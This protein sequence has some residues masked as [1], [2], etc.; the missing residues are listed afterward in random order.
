MTP[1]QEAFARNIVRGMNPKEAYEAAGYKARG[2]TASN[3]AQRLLKNPYVSRMIEEGKRLADNGAAWDRE[4]AVYRLV[5]VNTAS[6]SAIMRGSIGTNEV[7]AFFASEERLGALCFERKR[8]QEAPLFFFSREEAS[9]RA[10]EECER[11]GITSI[12]DDIPRNA[13]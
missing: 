10:M 13:P 3:E 11:N 7:K 4:K 1:K 12:I 2:H 5:S 6:F 9:G 8:E